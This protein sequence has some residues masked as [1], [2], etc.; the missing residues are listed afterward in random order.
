[1]LVGVDAPRLDTV[2]STPDAAGALRAMLD[3][4]E[5]FAPILDAADGMRAEL[6]RRGWSPTMAEGLAGQYLAALMQEGSGV[7]VM[8]ESGAY[9]SRRT[10][11][12]GAP[13]REGMTTNEE[14]P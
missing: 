11:G 4:N 10:T 8:A 12:D 6:E 5:A 3:V 14:N 7:R 1:M 9:E 13:S 2:V